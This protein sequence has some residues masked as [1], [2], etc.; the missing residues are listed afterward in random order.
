[1]K[2]LL[3]LNKIKL[4]L[5]I[6][7]IFLVLY[8]I[9]EV[10][11]GPFTSLD[12]FWHLRL[13]M[14]FLE[15]AWFPS[16]DHYSVFNDGKPYLWQTPWLFQILVASVYKIK[17]QLETLKVL[18]FFVFNIPFVT[19]LYFLVKKKISILGFILVSIF[20]FLA[21]INRSL[22]RPDTLVYVLSILNVY[23]YF[24]MR[25]N[26]NRAQYIQ[27]FLIQLFWSFY[28]SS[29]VIGL[30][31]VMLSQ[32]FILFNYFWQRKKPVNIPLPEVL[33]WNLLILLTGF[34][35]Y[36]FKHWFL[37][38]SPW[39]EWVGR[40]DEFKSLL[41]GQFFI[42]H[43]ALIL[44]FLIST[45][46]FYTKKSYD[47]IFLFLFFIAIWILH[48]RMT[49]H[50]LIIGS[51]L[52][53]FELAKYHSMNLQKW[54]ALFLM[55]GISIL[56]FINPLRNI[57]L[58]SFEFRYPKAVMDYIEKKNLKGPI[59]TEY[60]FASYIL[61]RRGDKNKVFMDGRAGQL[62]ST[63]QYLNFYK[64]INQ[65]KAFQDLVTKINVPFILVSE[66]FRPDRLFD[67]ITSSS[68]YYLEMEKDGFYIFSKDSELE[69]SSKLFST[70]LSIYNKINLEKVSNEYN[71]LK[72]NSSKNSNLL[73]M[74]K[75]YLEF[76]SSNNEQKMVL[77]SDPS[78][79]NKDLFLAFRRLLGQLALVMQQPDLSLSLYRGQGELK[80]LGRW[81]TYRIC[82]L[83]ISK[84]IYLPTYV[85]LSQISEQH[86][87]EEEMVYFYSILNLLHQYETVRESNVRIFNKPSHISLISIKDLE[88]KLLGFSLQDP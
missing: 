40:S 34:A 39:G 84:G 25:K 26:L 51:C 17:N 50:V 4:L 41:Q 6:V 52:L 3:F 87:S 32:V 14:D 66:N 81:D 1:M 53:A 55:V 54:S 46:Y 83:L 37:A 28:H 13:G 71:I 56:F 61:F 49:P 5:I 75:F 78:W 19:Y 16:V 27:V 12:L 29:A 33:I 45:M 79:Q 86:L 8:K 48:E 21:I 11:Y 85:L 72:S 73:E 9:K 58:P 43:Y 2:S 10:T 67:T 24:K 68:S 82:L 88:N 38:A 59:L 80:P 20:T 7:F 76:A 44:L 77:L 23:I 74:I 69:E 36:T 64:W 70:D 60:G 22:L 47:L 30:S 18:K 65:P 35:N 63:E 57:K 31:F 42:E 62:Y 15:K